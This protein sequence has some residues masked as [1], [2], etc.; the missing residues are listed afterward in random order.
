MSIDSTAIEKTARFIN[1]TGYA[2]YTAILNDLANLVGGGAGQAVTTAV[3]LSGLPASLDYTINITPNQACAA[4]WSAKTSSGFN[5][6]LTPLNT[7]DTIAAG[8][9]DVVVTWSL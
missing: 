4:S 8:T 3:A 1:T 5:V 6:V 9:F 2:V 7:G